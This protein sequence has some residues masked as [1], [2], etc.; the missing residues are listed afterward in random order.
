MKS[1]TKTIN[2]QKYK[3]KAFEELDIINKFKKTK[4]EWELINKYQKTFPQ[5]LINNTDDFVIDGETLCKELG[6]KSNFTDWLLRPQKG[7]EGKL[8]RYKCKEN[9]DYICTSGKSETQRKNGQKG[10]SIKNI[11]TLSLNCAKKIAMRQNNDNGDL[12]CDYFILM[13][14]VLKDHEIW[15]LIREPEKDGW[16]EMKSY[17]REWCIKRNYDE[18]DNYFYIREANMLNEALTGFTAIGIRNIKQVY[19]NQTRDNL[20]SITNNALSSLQKVNISLLIANMDF[21]K[22]KEIIED[23]CKTQY[24]HIKEMFL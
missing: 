22:R 9:I 7:K 2:G 20:D 6:I 1:F 21:E 17:I 14:N 8:I 15:T 24:I 4:E 16:N 13:E 5:L 10:I 19:D 11:I 12:V 18:K 3:G 23:T